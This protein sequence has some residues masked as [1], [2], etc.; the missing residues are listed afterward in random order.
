M[1]EEY[2]HVQAAKWATACEAVNELPRP[3][4]PFV[5]RLIDITRRSQRARLGRSS[6]DVRYVDHQQFG[7]TMLSK[8]CGGSQCAASGG[9]A[10]VWYQDMVE[11]PRRCPSLRRDQHHG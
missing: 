5:A 3:R 8:L 10:I 11:V 1:R 6:P 7:A 2:P 9:R 4:G